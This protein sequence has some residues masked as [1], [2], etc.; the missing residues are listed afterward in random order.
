MLEGC[1]HYG[2][3]HVQQERPQ[4]RVVFKSYSNLLSRPPNTVSSTA[5][6]NHQL[7]L[8]PLWNGSRVDLFQEGMHP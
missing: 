5:L 8:G 7:K 3:L 1:E 2:P 4:M 6:P